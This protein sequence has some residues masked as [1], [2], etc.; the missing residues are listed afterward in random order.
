M[1]PCVPE[2]ACIVILNFGT[3]G[4]LL[5]WE[6]L[7][8]SN[9]KIDVAKLVS[10]LPHRKTLSRHNPSRFWKTLTNDY[11][12]NSAL[13]VDRKYFDGDYWDSLYFSVTKEQYEK[14]IQQ[15]GD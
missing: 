3:T 14:S 4:N 7:L 15:A 11:I 6:E 8:I 5:D 12:G 9:G 2:Q 10:F 13:L 1:I